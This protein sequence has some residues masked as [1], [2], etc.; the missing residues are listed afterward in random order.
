[1]GKELE[2]AIKL[3]GIIVKSLGS[4]IKAAQSQFNTINKGIDRA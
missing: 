2:L 1:M 3:G 4:G